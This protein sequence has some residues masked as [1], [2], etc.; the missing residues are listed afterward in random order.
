[1]N[2][3]LRRRAYTVFLLFCLRIQKCSRKMADRTRERA[4]EK[5]LYRLAHDIGPVDLPRTRES[6]VKG[7]LKYEVK[8][9]ELKGASGRS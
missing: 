2:R 4:P 1:M 8:I 3:D 9:G 5:R 6:R 7:I